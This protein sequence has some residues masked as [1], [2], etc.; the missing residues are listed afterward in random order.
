MSKMIT[1]T[2]TQTQKQTQTKNTQDANV[3]KVKPKTSQMQRSLSNN[4]VPS[5]SRAPAR[6][7]NAPIEVH[8]QARNLN[9]LLILQNPNEEINFV[10]PR[11][12]YRKE[13][14]NMNY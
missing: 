7:P 14:E 13:I 9:M 6:D 1:K 12:E 5:A 11:T 8:G 4:I 10:K 2:K 3:T